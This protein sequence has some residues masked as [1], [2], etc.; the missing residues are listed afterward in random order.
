LNQIIIANL[1]NPTQP[2]L[3]PPWRLPG[4]CPEAKEGRSP[5]PKNNFT[6]FILKAL[7]P[8]DA[9]KRYL[10]WDAPQPSFGVRVTDNADAEGRAASISFVVVRRR[11]AMST[12][13]SPSWASTLA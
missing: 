8:A 7:K 1:G 12:R 9:G 13:S 6:D 10:L 4:V 3:T 5:W 2:S 11:P